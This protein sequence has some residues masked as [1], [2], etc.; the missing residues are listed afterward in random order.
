MRIALDLSLTAKAGVGGGNPAF[1]Q[2]GPTLDLVF[3]GPI[4]DPLR[5]PSEEDQTLI[6]DFTRAGFQ[7]AA[8]YAIWE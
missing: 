4:T 3:A 1:R 6:L 2:D 5:A 8:Q 7:V